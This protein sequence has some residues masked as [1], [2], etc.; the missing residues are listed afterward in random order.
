MDF[1]D[2]VDHLICAQKM[3]A[4]FLIPFFSLFFWAVMHYRLQTHP[5]IPVSL[6]PLGWNVKPILWSHPTL[7]RGRSCCIP[8][9]WREKQ[10][11]IRRNVCASKLGQDT[12]AGKRKTLDTEALWLRKRM[13]F[14]W[15]LWWLWPCS[16]VSTIYSEVAL[17]PRTT[18][19]LSWMTVA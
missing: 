3:H 16:H 4:V 15:D 7:T 1:V 6:Q 19:T 13:S 12:L 18:I 11:W 2:R 17:G 10:S 9:I 8:P 5:R 14:P